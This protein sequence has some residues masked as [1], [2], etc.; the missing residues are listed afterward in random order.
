[1]KRLPNNRQNWGASLR[2]LDGHTD[3]VHAVGFSKD[4]RTLP[5]AS[6]DRTVRL[7]EPITGPLLQILEG[8]TSPV[9]DGRLLKE[10]PFGAS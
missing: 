7:W 5:E 1:M 10:W 6:N 3:A 8:H 4:G 9:V 2:T